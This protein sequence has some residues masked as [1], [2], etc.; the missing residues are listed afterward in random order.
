MKAKNPKAQELW[1]RIIIRKKIQ[2]LTAQYR[3]ILGISKGGFK[4]GSEIL[5]FEEK[6]E[7]DPRLHDSFEQYIKECREDTDIAEEF[8]PTAMLNHL[9][10]RGE[11]NVSDINLSG[12]QIDISEFLKTGKLK[13]EIRFDATIKDLKGFINQKSKYIRFLQQIYLEMHNLKLKR[14]KPSPNDIRD[15]HIYYFMTNYTKKELY[16]QLKNIRSA[17]P[18]KEKSKKGILPMEDKMSK[19]EIL[20]R[21][22]RI[23]PPPFQM[24]VGMSAIKTATARQKRLR[25]ESTK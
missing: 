11:V 3:D 15:M 21:L 17:L 24:N 5:E 22:L 16:E 14:I 2:E 13:I 23:A 9:T 8:I 12:C 6:I 7:T 25:E 4:K 1:R 19:E 18:D 20:E 10:Y